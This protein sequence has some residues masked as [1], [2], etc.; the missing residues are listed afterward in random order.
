MGKPM[1]ITVRMKDFQATFG[2]SRATAYRRAKEGAFPLYKLPPERRITVVKVDEVQKW[3]ESS[4][5]SLGDQ[6][7]D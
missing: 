6:M 5:I 1:P 7:G 3:L 4:G 2:I